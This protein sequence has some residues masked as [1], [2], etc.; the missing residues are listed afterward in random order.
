MTCTV[1]EPGIQGAGV[2][3]I[4]GPGVNAPRAAAVN[5]AVIGFARLLHTPKGMIFIKGL[6]SKI[7]N[8]SKE[9]PLVMFL[10]GIIRGVGAT[11]IGH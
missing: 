7:V 1:G 11:P 9:K 8:T 5:A 3:G 6:L 2:N 4:Q 10:G